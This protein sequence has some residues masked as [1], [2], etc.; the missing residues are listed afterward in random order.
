MIHFLYHPHFEKQIAKLKKKY[1]SLE[2]DFEVFCLARETDPVG[3]LPNIVPIAWLGEWVV[4]PIYKVRKFPLT[5][6]KLANSGIRIIYAYD[7]HSSAIE[8]IEFAEIYHKNDQEDHDR[9]FLI[10]EYTG[11]ADLQP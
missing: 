5:C 9:E 2:K 7:S 11:K 1:P 10:R 8:F 6:M 4:L 3:Y